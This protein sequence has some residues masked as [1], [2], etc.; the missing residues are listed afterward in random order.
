MSTSRRGGGTR[1]FLERLEARD[2]RERELF[3]RLGK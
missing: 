3:E 2:E 1:R